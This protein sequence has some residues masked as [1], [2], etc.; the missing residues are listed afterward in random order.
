MYRCFLLNKTVSTVSI[1]EQ[2]W[3]VFLVGS[4][5]VGKS[6][7]A[8]LLAGELKEILGRRV[9]VVCDEDKFEDTIVRWYNRNVKDFEWWRG[10]TFARLK[11]LENVIFVVEDM[12]S[13]TLSQPKRLALRKLFSTLARTKKSLLLQQA[14][15]RWIS[16]E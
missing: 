11:K 3:G 13:Q 5:G 1:P 10:L 14:K 7:L 16:L 8:S 2:H 9:I 6:Q 12:P 4:Q 15:S